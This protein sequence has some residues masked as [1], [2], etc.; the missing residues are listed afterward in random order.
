MHSKCLTS[1]ERPRGRPPKR[2]RGSWA[3]ISLDSYAQKYFI[4]CLCCQTQ[5]DLKIL[6]KY[7]FQEKVYCGNLLLMYCTRVNGFQ[8]TF[9]KTFWRSKMCVE[10]VFNEYLFVAKRINN[11]TKIKLFIDFLL[12]FLRNNVPNYYFR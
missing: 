10:Y 2:W 12:N 4:V 5:K 8:K 6:R 7:F 9:N 11:L 1:G 3:F